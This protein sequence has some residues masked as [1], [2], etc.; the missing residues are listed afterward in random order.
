MINLGPD[1]LDHGTRFLFDNILDGVRDGTCLMWQ[2]WDAEESRKV[3]ILG[4]KVPP[5]KVLPIAVLLNPANAVKRYAP[6][7]G[8]DD[9]DWS[10][11]T[12]R[13]IRP[14]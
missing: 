6:A 12:S 10:Q 2:A 8:P 4:R 7:K 3:W 14:K 5:D 13:I 11:I 9:F 1:S